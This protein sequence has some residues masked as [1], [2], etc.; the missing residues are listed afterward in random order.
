ML[1][2]LRKIFILS[3]LFT[4]FENLLKQCEAFPFRG[5]CVLDLQIKRAE[6]AFI[7]L[8]FSSKSEVLPSVKRSCSRSEVFALG[9]S[10]LLLLE[11][12]SLFKVTSPEGLLIRLKTALMLQATFPHKGR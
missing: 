9:K 7:K 1:I 12:Q 3:L 10:E 2:L 5:R 6:E 4:Q 11:S 8:S